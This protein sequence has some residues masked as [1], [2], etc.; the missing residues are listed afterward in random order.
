MAWDRRSPHGNR[1]SS[2]A[3]G[4]AGL[5]PVGGDRKYLGRRNTPGDDIV[6]SKPD[7]GADMPKRLGLGLL[8][9]AALANSAWAQTVTRFDGQYVGELTLNGIVNGDCTKPPLGAAY[10]LTISGGVVRFKY[11][12]RFDTTLVGTIDATGNFRASATLHHG[13]ATMTGRIEGYRKL[14]AQ[15]QSPSCLYTFQTKE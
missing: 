5:D 1:A 10:P 4:T 8:I 15:L 11:V 7:R 6:G 3:G 2:S 12:P 9:A 13:V 14:T